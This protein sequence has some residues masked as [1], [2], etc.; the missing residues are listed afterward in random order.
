MSN[1][2]CSN[3]SC[4][5]LFVAEKV[6]QLSPEELK[7]LKEEL[8]EKKRLE[9]EKMKEEIKKLMQEEKE[10]KKEER[11]KVSWAVVSEIWITLVTH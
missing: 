4:L 7:K 10:K 9:K 3:E 5:A 8:K 11:L 2:S 6:K 1:C